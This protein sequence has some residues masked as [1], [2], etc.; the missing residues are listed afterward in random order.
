[1][2]KQEHEQRQKQEQKQEHEQRQEQEQKQEQD[3]VGIVFW[4]DLWA[5]VITGLICRLL[6]Q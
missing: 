5:N 2:Q 3:N 1:M 4:S 6:E